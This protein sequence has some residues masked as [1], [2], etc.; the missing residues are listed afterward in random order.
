MQQ[1]MS[2]LVSMHDLVPSHL[3]VSNRRWMGISLCVFGIFVK[4]LEERCLLNQ[5]RCK[6][7]HARRCFH[8]LHRSRVKHL[9][10]LAKKTA[11]VPQ[12]LLRVVMASLYAI[13]NVQI[14]TCF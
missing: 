5:V 2:L 10:I 3:P 1:V 8:K 9:C 11:E 12:M 7:I 13:A 6:E 14:L 4:M